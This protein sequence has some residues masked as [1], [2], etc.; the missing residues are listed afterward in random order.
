[1]SQPRVLAQRALSGSGIP[2]RAHTCHEHISCLCQRFDCNCC[3]GQNLA[4][5]YIVGCSFIFEICG[6]FSLVHL[7]ALNSRSL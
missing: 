5:A 1:M 3:L 2:V 4:Q 6:F 7:F